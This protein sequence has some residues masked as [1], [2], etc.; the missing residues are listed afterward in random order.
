MKMSISLLF[1]PSFLIN[2]SM[3]KGLYPHTIQR[4]TAWGS[5]VT[6]RI[7]TGRFPKLRGWGYPSHKIGGGAI[8]V[9]ADRPRT[10]NL[11][12]MRAR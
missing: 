7:T 2:P 10:G 6:C 5:S 12:V 8:W 4:G 9:K 3:I 1:T 11:L